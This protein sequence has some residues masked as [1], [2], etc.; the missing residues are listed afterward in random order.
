M[1]ARIVTQNGPYYVEE[2]PG[3]YPLPEEINIEGYLEIIR[4]PSTYASIH[5]NL[6]VNTNLPGYG[7]CL[8]S[9]DLVPGIEAWR[10]MYLNVVIWKVESGYTEAEIWVR[11]EV[12]TGG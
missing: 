12:E 11:V 4:E 8:P 1:S 10:A 2:G 5:T 3:F 7:G 9:E 6:T